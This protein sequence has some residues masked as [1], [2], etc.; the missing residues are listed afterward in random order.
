MCREDEEILILEVGGN[1]TQGK[2]NPH[3]RPWSA[4]LRSR[5]KGIEETANPLVS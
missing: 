4:I 5:V 1:L 3:A 2:P